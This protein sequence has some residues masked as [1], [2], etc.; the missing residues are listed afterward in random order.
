MTPI[1]MVAAHMRGDPIPTPPADD[2]ELWDLIGRV[3]AVAAAARD[4]ADQLKTELAARLGDNAVR[5]GDTVIRTVP[6]RTDRIV[7]PD[8]LVAWLGDDW[9]HVIPVTP[10]TRIRRRGL[11][12]VAQRRGFDPD[13]TWDTFVATEWGEPRLQAVPVSRAPKWAQ[14]LAPGERSAR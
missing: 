1:R 6:D 2:E 11:E 10:S 7:D 4:L 5:I 3:E 12:A 9:P 8:A 13:I 14:Q